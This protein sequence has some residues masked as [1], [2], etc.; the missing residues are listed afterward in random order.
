MKRLLI[1]PLLALVACVSE[2]KPVSDA[3][4]VT[5]HFEPVIAT[6]E[7][8]E[9]LR[10]ICAALAAKEGQLSILAS[11]N[12]EY[13]FS[14]AQ[15]DCY[16]SSLPALKDVVTTIKRAG[17]SYI[18]SPKNNESFGF[19][20]VETTTEGVM[21]ELCRFGGA[22]ESPVRERDSSSVGIWWTTFVST[23]HCHPGYGT[24]CIHLQTGVTSDGRTYKINKDEWIKFKLID[25]NQ[26]FFV[27]R[28][29]VSSAGCSKGKTVEIKAILK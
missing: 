18:F 14:Y 1:L 16:E 12:R 24:L 9:R 25:P 7:D 2:D 8:Q 28:K 13:T 20:N 10:S 19:D 29:V 26:G 27:E 15:K 4:G 21:R 6:V 23:Q 22:A 3:V 11:M 17:S 5:R